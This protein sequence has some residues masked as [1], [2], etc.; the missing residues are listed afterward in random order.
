MLLLNKPLPSMIGNV[1]DTRKLEIHCAAIAIDIA[2]PLTLLGKISDNN[3]HVTGPNDMA[4]EAIN[5][6][7]GIKGQT[8]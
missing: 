2:L 5:N 1:I 7:I 6:N 8:H 4:K 3:T